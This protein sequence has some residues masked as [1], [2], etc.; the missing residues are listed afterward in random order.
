MFSEEFIERV[1]VPK[2]NEWFEFVLYGLVGLSTLFTTILLTLPSQYDPYKDKPLVFKNEEGTEIEIMGKDGKK[3]AYFKQGR[4]TQVVVL[5]DIGRSPRMQYH[6]LSIADHGG[7]VYLIG[8]QESEIHPDIVADD[9]IEVVPLA[10]APAFLRSS[11]KLLFPIVAP[12]KAL[13]QAQSLYHALGYRT[14]PARYM[15]VQNPPSIPTLAIAT[16]VSFWRN[17]ELVVDWHN[18][19]YTI[20]ALKLGDS[21]PL[22]VIASWYEYIFARFAS[23]HFAVTDA[24]ARV[25]KQVYGVNALT[26]HD[27]PA[28]LFQPI[29]G[30]ERLKFLNYLPE[31][32]QYAKDLAPS[33]KMPW[34]LIVSSTSWTAD[35]DFSILLDALSKYSAQATSNT[36]LPRIL[37]IITGKGPQKDHYLSKIR[38]M[39]QEKK[40]L[41]VVIQT[42]WL[43]PE[44]YALLLAAADLGVSLHTSSSGVDLP[45]KVVDMFGA[46]LPVV[47]WGKFEAWPELVTEDV[48]GKGFESSEQLAE[49][50]I[51]LFG[52]KADLLQTLKQGAVKESENTWDHEWDRVAGKLFK[53]V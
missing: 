45:M 26:L 42:A 3:K 44:H 29:D 47:G 2:F 14:E 5:G 32:A 9:L 38:E 18:F 49:Q 39:N 21:H 11:S 46:G 20:L 24:M 31:T 53:L 1:L 50:L 12:L 23:H 52:V 33:S 10:P 48:N 35:E 6:A 30:K 28:D 15:L 4:T 41:N 37:A 16:L 19:G 8:Y 27:R 34:K 40:L 7:R 13:W 17:T 43:T 36:S 25:L 51:D 22:V